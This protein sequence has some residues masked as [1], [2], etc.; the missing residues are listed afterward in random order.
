M[1]DQGPTNGRTSNDYRRLGAA[2]SYRRPARNITGPVDPTRMKPVSHGS[3]GIW[4]VGSG[5]EVFN[6]SLSGRVGS[7]GLQI[8]RVESGQEV[9][10]ISRVGSGH[11]PTSQYFRGSSGQLTRPDPTREVLPDPRTGLQYSTP[12]ESH[13]YILS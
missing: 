8:P 1:R 3:I 11:D 13:R 7:K 6:I 4:P 5:Q 2:S 10:K 9:S 12:Y